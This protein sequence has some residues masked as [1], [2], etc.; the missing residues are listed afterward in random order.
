MKVIRALSSQLIV[1]S[2]HGKAEGGDGS[3]KNED[4]GIA[5]KDIS[6]SPDFSQREKDF[7]EISWSS[8]AERDGDTFQS[9]LVRLNQL[10]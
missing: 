4:G 6:P 7:F 5:G 3:S 8:L 9:R 10:R 1:A 2:C